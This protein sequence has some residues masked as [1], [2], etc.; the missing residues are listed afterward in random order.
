MDRE[1]TSGERW[2]VGVLGSIAF[3]FITMIM[4]ALGFLVLIT[5]TTFNLVSLFI[6]SVIFLFLRFT[7]KRIIYG[8]PSKPSPRALIIFGCIWFVF[9][10]GLLLLI[11]NPNLNDQNAN[12]YAVITSMVASFSWVCISWKNLKKP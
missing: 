7:L 1:P 12:I 10:C 9:S 3:I 5:P 8:S 6:V 11:L 2:I 4:I